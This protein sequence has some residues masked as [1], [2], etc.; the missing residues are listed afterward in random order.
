MPRLRGRQPL[1]P[2]VDGDVEPPCEGIGEGLCT[3]SLRAQCAAEGEGE[4]N[5]KLLC[6]LFPGQLC[7][8]LHRVGAGIDSSDGDGHAGVE[9]GSGDADTLLAGVYT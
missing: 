5:D 1:V 2:S 7:H 4:A 6:V 9:V 3:L 8:S